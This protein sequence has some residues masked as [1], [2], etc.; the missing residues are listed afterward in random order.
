MNHALDT[1]K[2]QRKGCGPQNLHDSSPGDG[3]PPGDGWSGTGKGGATGDL[4]DL[5][6]RLSE[7][8]SLREHL[9]AQIGPMGAPLMLDVLARHLVEDLDEHGFLRA[10][11]SEI[12]FRLG[13]GERDLNEALALVQSCE[14]TGVGARDLAECLSLQLAERGHLSGPMQRL[15]ANLHRLERG[16]IKRLRQICDVDEDSF[17]GLLAQ[18][19]TLDPRPCADFDTTEPETLIPD[20]LLSRAKWGG[21]HLELNAETLPRL[22]VNNAYAAELGHLDG[23]EARSFVADCRANASWLVKSLD[24]RA[25][26]ILRVATEIVSQQE[27]FFAQGITGLRPL[28]LKDVAEQLDLHE[29]TISRVTSNKY[30]ATERGIFELKFFFSNALG[31]GET[32][33]AE[34]VRHR[35]KAMID[36]ET[37]DD[38][39]SDDTIVDMLRG[40]GIDIARRTVAKYRKSL[41]IPSSV[42]RRRRFALAQR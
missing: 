7:H 17:N 39:L 16:E 21:W 4:P 11:L 5:D 14:P 6:Q 35:I 38:V 27:A 37:A 33:A 23:E 2:Q 29:S 22:I 30:M 41:K 3:P 10:D 19:R 28:T 13:A 40:S 32:H 24:Q 31:D 8:L 42:D 9:L 25:R 34:A 20:I 18:L 36:T 1:I 15:L 26:T 12:G